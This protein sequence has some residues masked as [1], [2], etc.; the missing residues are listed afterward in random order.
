MRSNENPIPKE[1]TE[2]IKEEVKKAK[3]AFGVTCNIIKT[4]GMIGN[5]VL[6]GALYGLVLTNPVALPIKIFAGISGLLVSGV[7]TDKTDA[8]V[9]KIAYSANMAVDEAAEIIANNLN[10]YSKD[11]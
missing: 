8:Y 1:V 10:D 4:A 2:V 11:I 3:N 5:S 9:D 7:L 6:V